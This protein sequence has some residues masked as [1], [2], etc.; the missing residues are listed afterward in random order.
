ME[1][2]HN[3]DGTEKRMLTGMFADRDSTERAY[4]R[5]SERGYTNDEVNLLMSDETRE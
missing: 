5:L 4:A 1:N 3:P 2:A